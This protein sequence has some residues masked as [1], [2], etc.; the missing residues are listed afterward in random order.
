M[1]V[2]VTRNGLVVLEYLDGL[3]E[4]LDGLVTVEVA[5]EPEE[6]EE[7]EEEPVAA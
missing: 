6:Q 4:V 1:R 7:L 2:K 5:G 3:R